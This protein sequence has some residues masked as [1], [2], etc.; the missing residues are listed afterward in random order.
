MHRL[1]SFPKQGSGCC[2][3]ALLLHDLL[4]EVHVDQALIDLPQQRNTIHAS[5][6]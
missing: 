1:L 4:A 5:E 3:V 2:T 6:N